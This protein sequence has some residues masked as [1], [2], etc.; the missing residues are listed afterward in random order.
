MV[1]KI[2]RRKYNSGVVGHDGSNAGRPALPTHLKRKNHTI[3][4]TDEEWALIK[5]F[6]DR[7]KKGI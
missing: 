5:E 7:L 1:E 4:A 2:D 6:S 3:R